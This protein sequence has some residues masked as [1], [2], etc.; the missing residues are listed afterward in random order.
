MCRQQAAPFMH[1]V[2]SYLMSFML[3][4]AVLGYVEVSH[5]QFQGLGSLTSSCQTGVQVLLNWH[6][7]MLH[8]AAAASAAWLCFKECSEFAVTH[9]RLLEPYPPS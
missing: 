2:M 3:F 5:A 7:A 8:I 6:H 4:P 1:M 9:C